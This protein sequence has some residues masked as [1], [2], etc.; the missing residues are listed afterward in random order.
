MGVARLF[1]APPG[2]LYALYRE[3][4][5]Y[6]QLRH[7]RPTAH[8]IR[9]GG[10][11]WHFKLNGPFDATIER[12]RW[13]SVKSARIYINEAAAEDTIHLLSPLGKQRV[14]DGVLI[15]RKLV[16]KAFA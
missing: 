12:G 7:E 8:G 4:V 10:A 9:R 14:K 2:R 3:A 6:F 11:S 13:S 16:S 1:N 15:Y 5:Q